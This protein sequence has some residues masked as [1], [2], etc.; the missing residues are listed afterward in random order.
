MSAFGIF[1]MLLTT[2]LIAYYAVTISRDVAAGQKKADDSSESEIFELSPSSEREADDSCR[3]ESVAVYETENGFVVG[4]SE[5]KSE[6]ILAPATDETESQPVQKSASENAAAID[7]KLEDTDE[8]V[9]FEKAYDQDDFDQFIIN[10]N[11]GNSHLFH[12]TETV[13]GEPL[14]PVSQNDD[15]AG[16]QKERDW[17]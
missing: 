15:S 11:N 9:N 10:Q 3:T 12:K 16:K 2:A 5:T 8:Q 4:Q 7:D 14:K 17:M 1:A 13:A 6:T